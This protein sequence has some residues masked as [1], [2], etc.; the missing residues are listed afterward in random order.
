MERDLGTSPAWLMSG[1][2]KVQSDWGNCTC[3]CSQSFKNILTQLAYA[4]VQAYM[5]VRSKRVIG[6]AFTAPE[7]NSSA[8]PHKSL[9]NEDEC[10]ESASKSN[11]NSPRCCIRALWVVPGHRRKGVATQLL[12]A[13]RWVCSSWSLMYDHEIQSLIRRLLYYVFSQDILPLWT[14]IATE[15]VNFLG[16]DRR[17]QAICSCVLWNQCLQHLPII[18]VT[19]SQTGAR[20]ALLQ[21]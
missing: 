11:T 4:C 9:R 19:S 16:A 18:T 6:C 8:S 20:S 17:W 14:K 15:R 5:F 10:T 7:E 2:W 3:Q 13:V 1:E 21:S 12:D